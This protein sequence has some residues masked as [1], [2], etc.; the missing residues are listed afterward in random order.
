MAEL[1]SLQKVGVHSQ[2]DSEIL[3]WALI[4]L[5][6]EKHCVLEIKIMGRTADSPYSGVERESAVLEKVLQKVKTSTG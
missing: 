2:Q 1:H 4:N 6:K 3:R 5:G